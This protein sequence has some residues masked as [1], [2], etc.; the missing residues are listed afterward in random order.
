MILARATMMAVVYE[1]ANLMGA[2]M[3]LV[4]PHGQE[5]WAAWTPV[6]L[7]FA[8]ALRGMQRLERLR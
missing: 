4:L 1:I 6:L 2:S 7:I 3:A 8:A 5:A